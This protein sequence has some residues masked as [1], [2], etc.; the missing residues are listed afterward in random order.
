MNG[1]Y[2]YILFHDVLWVIEK[3]DYSLDYKFNELNVCYIEQN[4]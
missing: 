4:I 1:S 3:F 2:V